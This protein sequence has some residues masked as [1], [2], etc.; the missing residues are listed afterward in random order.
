MQ[1]HC[2]PFISGCIGI[3]RKKKIKVRIWPITIFKLKEAAGFWLR[4]YVTTSFVELQKWSELQI[5]SSISFFTHTFIIIF[6]ACGYHITSLKKPEKNRFHV[7]PQLMLA[8]LALQYKHTQKNLKEPVT[9]IRPT[10]RYLVC[11][12]WGLMLT[13]FPWRSLSI[14]ASVRHHRFSFPDRA[15]PS[16]SL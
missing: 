5:S 11:I 15:A 2:L 3:G 13:Q 8:E 7:T 9:G 10:T 14:T 1:I 6:R 4:W 12:K 16:L